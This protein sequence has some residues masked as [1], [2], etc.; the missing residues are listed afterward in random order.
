MVDNDVVKM[1]NPVAAGSRADPGSINKWLGIGG[2][3]ET[4]GPADTVDI[5]RIKIRGVGW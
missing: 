1:L 2:C 4:H 3:R 5:S